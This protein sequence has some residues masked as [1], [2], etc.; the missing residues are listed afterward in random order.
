[1][2]E[3]DAA[4]YQLD[5]NAAAAAGAGAVD[6][7]STF[8]LLM[9][10]EAKENNF[11]AVLESIRDTL[12]ETIIIPEWLRDIFLGYGD[13]GAA[14]Y[15]QMAEGRL[16]TVDFRVSGRGRVSSGGCHLGVTWVSL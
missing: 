5:L 3:L 2:V 12:N 6:I 1:V 9:R 15:S 7:Y 8:N 14:H 13:P 10:R 16:D 4:Q 11:K